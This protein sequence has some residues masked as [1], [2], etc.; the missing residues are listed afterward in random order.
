MQFQFTP[1]TVACGG[2]GCP[3]ELLYSGLLAHPGLQ[4]RRARLLEY[5]VHLAD[6]V[7]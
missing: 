5:E 1:G 6:L 4:L 3:Y 7:Q 2:P